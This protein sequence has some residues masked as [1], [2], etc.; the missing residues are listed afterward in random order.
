MAKSRNQPAEEP[1]DTLSGLLCFSLY[2]A[3]HAMTR[4]LKPMLA[5]LGVTYPQFVTLVALWDEDDQLV[6]EIGD[7]LYL[8]SNTLTPLLKRLEALGFVKRQRDTEDERR[9]RVKLTRAG[10]QLER[11]TAR[12]PAALLEA[13]GLSERQFAR[14]TGEI[15][16][17]REQLRSRESGSR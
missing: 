14:L 10:K 16:D 15:R 5:E 8:E 3:S 1:Q 6:S 9:V 2:S 12:F 11:K 17:V 4:V 13:T 7:K